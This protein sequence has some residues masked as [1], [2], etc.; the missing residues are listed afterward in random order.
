MID[1]EELR[2]KI[3]IKGLDV[4]ADTDIL[5]L[6]DRLEAA[7]AECLEEAR[8]N[9]MGSEREAALMARVERLERALIR[10]ANW[11]EHNPQCAID[12]GSNGVRNYYRNIA[13]AALEELK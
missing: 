12:H 11:S 9:G 13:R 1:I 6:F 8:L 5:E 10:I 3:T 4:V 2:E 7:E